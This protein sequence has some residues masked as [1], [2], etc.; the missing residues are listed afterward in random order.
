[1]QEDQK[2]RKCVAKFQVPTLHAYSQKCL[3]ISSQLVDPDMVNVNHNTEV[4]S[5]PFSQTY[6]LPIK[7]VVL[8]REL[9]NN[10]I[11]FF[12]DYWYCLLQYN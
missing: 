9:Q 1:M 8:F 7:L 5:V 6:N 3:C 10:C 11:S 2:W 4:T 12:V